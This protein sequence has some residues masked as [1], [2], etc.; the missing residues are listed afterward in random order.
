VRQPNGHDHDSE[1][2]FFRLLAPCRYIGEDADTSADLL[3]VQRLSSLIANNFREYLFALC[4]LVDSVERSMDRGAYGYARLLLLDR[5]QELQDLD[6]KYRGMQPPPR[7][8][9]SCRRSLLQ[10][11]NQLETLLRTDPEA[12]SAIDGGELK[13]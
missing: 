6:L 1:H 5:Q 7:D 3:A 12:V 2:R 9:L 8:Y 4:L 10:A 13:E 11:I